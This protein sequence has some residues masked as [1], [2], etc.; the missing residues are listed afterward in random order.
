MRGPDDKP[1]ALLR[2]HAA[3]LARL[4]R[5]SPLTLLVHEASSRVDR[6]VHEGLLP[7]TARRQIDRAWPGSAVLPHAPAADARR[8][9]RVLQLHA[10]QGRDPAALLRQ[11][12][13]AMLPPAALPGLS[14]SATL[15]ELLA[16]AQAKSGARLLLVVRQ[17]DR[18]LS[19]RNDDPGRC[20]RLCDALVDLASAPS[21]RVHILLVV[22]ERADA[23][24]ET[25]RR[26]LPQLDDHRLRVGD[27][28]APLQPAPRA[29]SPRSEQDFQRSL[30]AMLLRVANF[31]GPNARP[32]PM[33][34]RAGDATALPQAKAG[35]QPLA[36]IR[37]APDNRTAPV[38]AASRVPWVWGPPAAA[39]AVLAGVPLLM[40]Q[41]LPKAPVGASV[42]TDLSATPSTLAQRAVAVMPASAPPATASYDKA[43]P[44]LELAQTLAAAG[45]PVQISGPDDAWAPGLASLSRGPGLAVARYDVLPAARASG[46]P[47]WRG[48]QLQPGLPAGWPESASAAGELQRCASPTG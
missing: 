17:L 2:Q 15:P 48:V 11:R 6:L 12:Q 1:S 24:L 39:L 37:D 13:L 25:L 31:A 3:W 20:Q 28:A 23:L 14:P 27:L 40:W 21:Q 32:E 47:A 34:G 7:L 29:V 46:A 10:L 9:E 43:G 4:W 8:P 44:A 18:L 26:R 16:S 38:A 19:P 33:R 5:L 22:D 36:D 41:T 42:N 35:A 30:D 45:L